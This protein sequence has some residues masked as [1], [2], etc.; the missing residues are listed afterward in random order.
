MNECK[1]IRGL[2]ALRPDDW[3]ASE[4]SQVE[5]HL[6]PCPD[7]AALAHA[8][9]EQDRL[10]RNAPRVGLTP[11]QRDQLLL[12]IQR[13]KKRR[14]EM[15]IRL[16]AILGTATTIVAFIALAFGL[17][18]LF[19]QR[20]QP[21][22]GAPSG[23]YPTGADE[24]LWV[25]VD[26]AW[27]KELA[28][29]TTTILQRQ[30]W[31][32]GEIILFT[33][34]DNLPDSAGGGCQRVL[35]WVLVEPDPLELGWTV[36]MSGNEEV[37]HW[38]ANQPQPIPTDVGTHGFWLSERRDSLGRTMSVIYG[39]WADPLDVPEAVQ[40]I[41]NSQ[42]ID[43][44][45]EDGSFLYVSE[46]HLAKERPRIRW[47]CNSPDGGLCGI[48]LRTDEPLPM[49]E[50]LVFAGEIRS[51][52]LAVDPLTGKRIPFTLG[53][54]D[55]TDLFAPGQLHV[56]VNVHF[57]L[58]WQVV[59]PPSADWRVFVHLED[60]AGEMALQSDVAVDWP[61]QPCPEDEY[62]PAE[63]ITIT[64]HEWHF[65]ADFPP[66]LYN[67]RVGL[68]NPATGMRA[69]VPSPSSETSSV[70]LG[71]VRV[72]SDESASETAQVT[73]G[74]FS[75][76][77]D[78]TWTLTLAQGA[79]LRQLLN[80]LPPTDQPF[81]DEKWF[82]SGYHGFQLQLGGAGGRPPQFVQ[83]YKGIVQVETEGKIVR[84]ADGDY[85][86][87][88]WLLDTAA[89]HI[90]PDIADIIETIHEELKTLS[91][92]TPTPRPASLSPLLPTPPPVSIATPVVHVI[93]EGDTILSIATLE[94]MTLT[95]TIPFT[96]CQS[97]ETWTRPSEAE[98]AAQVWDVPRRQD[99]PREM[100]WWIFQQ[101]FYRYSGGNSEMFDTWPELGLW[102]VEDPYIC[103]G[104]RIGD[105]VTGLE[106]ELW[107]LLHRVVA[108]QRQGNEYIVTVKP[109]PA[110]YQV[111]RLP[112]PGV[113]NAPVTVR[114]VDAEGRETDR[115]PK[116]PP[117]ADP[118]VPTAHDVVTVTGTA[119]DNALSAQVVTL[120]DADGVKWHLPWM[121]ATIVRW[122]DGTPAQF[123][124]VTPGATLDV[125]GFRRTE[126]VTPNT[127]SAVR[128]D[129]LAARVPIL[130][131]VPAP[132]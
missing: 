14:R 123:E 1:R 31:W 87:E 5:A 125:A 111:A 27:D 78:P 9:A 65:P 6:T 48:S 2:L 97:S 91:P 28:H 79:E 45:L 60:E 10:I 20:S 16:P 7:C 126:S 73:L 124:D 95:N 80:T 67:I 100:L 105:I 76:R 122:L 50:P 121:D 69:P 114:F 44:P 103:E 24:A 29:Q 104:N 51:D 92:A 15:Q 34:E 55:Q 30:P 63:C 72:V 74:I 47:A 22:P 43:V 46:G 13:E 84:L 37:V 96:I 42:S 61:P 66:G 120:E 62:N 89:P 110:G 32:D 4:R 64:E 39:L 93:Q 94:T 128:V 85:A 81:D 115:L 101:P 58:S 41:Q 52:E 113:P 108:A 36:I 90:E 132:E 116:L 109:T 56:P 102:T 118:D 107:V 17:S 127:L 3:N 11:P 99:I 129:I 49:P 12:R 70:V 83:V 33:Y 18:A 106:S 130:E 82:P 117:W 54:R 21:T 86:L 35:S 19:Q 88:R 68:Y 131:T 38:P 119:V 57:M 8:Y 53:E 77:L 59:T 98:Q 71:Q 75:G 23:P 40:L 112:G 26:S 25:H